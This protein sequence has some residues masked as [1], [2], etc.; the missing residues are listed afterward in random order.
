MEIKHNL[1]LHLGEGP[2]WDERLESLFFVDIMDKKFYQWSAAN[3]ISKAYSFDEYISC[4]ALTEDSNIIQ[5][6]LESGIYSFNLNTSKKVFIQQPEQ[7]ANYRYNDGAVDPYGNWLLG[8]MNNINNGPEA[9]LQPDAALYHI[10]GSKSHVL[11]PHVTIS[12]GIVFK[13]DHLYF[14]D[15]KLNTI[16][17]FLYNGEVLGE[18]EVIFTLTDGTT[19]DGMTI[20]QSGKLYIAN[21]G[22][23]KILVFDLASQRIVD[24]IPVP[25]LNPT[26]CT[27]GGAELNELFITTS[28]ID[29][30]NPQLAGVYSIKLDDYG[31]P[32]YK[33]K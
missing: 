16:R 5:I 21:W 24:E 31:F 29:D 25:A 26:S 13:D 11:L 33:L 27:F 12:N 9:T 7:K 22:G 6:A 4:L 17:R 30:P 23:H 18:E 20:S 15:S 28:K 32:E 1:A 14:I 2:I 19:L 8:S 3:N 10:Q